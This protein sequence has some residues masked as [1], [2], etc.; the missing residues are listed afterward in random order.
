MKIFLDSANLKE[1]EEAVSLGIID[2]V[3]TNPSLMA[4]EGKLSMLKIAGRICQLVKGPVSLEGGAL[5]FKDMVNEGKKLARISKNVVVKIP[6]TKDGIKAVSILASQGIKTNVT[7]IFT[8]NQAILAAK[9]GATFVSPFIGRLDDIGE[10]GIDL[11]HELVVVFRNYGTK[12]QILAASIRNP[13]Q[14]RQSAV[15]GAHIVTI[16]F[17]ILTAMYEHQL[18]AKGIEIFQKAWNEKNKKI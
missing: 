8:V 18:T 15:A 10:T 2:G 5:N 14:V 11:I 17:K 3:T 12:T 6:M 1:I 9:A 13:N 7:L 16:P 4:K